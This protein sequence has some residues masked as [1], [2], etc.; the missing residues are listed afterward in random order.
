MHCNLKKKAC[1][2]S[3]QGVPTLHWL[4]KNKTY[5]A[6]LY[7]IILQVM[8]VLSSFSCH[9]GQLPK[10]TIYKKTNT[11]LKH[12]SATCSYMMPAGLLFN[13]LLYFQ[14][15]LCLRIEPTPSSQATGSLHPKGTAPIIILTSGKTTG[16]QTH[17]ITHFISDRLDFQPCDERENK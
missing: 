6:D 5:S 11:V 10:C 7:G 13:K 17:L 1:L 12:R 4:H 9:P 3:K 14:I 2:S 16:M 8:L 15:Y